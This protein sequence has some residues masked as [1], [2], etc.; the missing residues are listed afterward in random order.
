M[1]RRRSIV[2]GAGALALVGLSLSGCVRSTSA[3]RGIGVLTSAPVPSASP[4]AVDG[5]DA[6]DTAMISLD[7]G[8]DV[9]V[10]YSGLTATGRMDPGHH[11]AT[12]DFAGLQD[13]IGRASCRER[14]LR[15]V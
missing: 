4:S 3:V 7:R 8:Y 13:E 15:L 12:V 5:T 1:K 11:A 2:A 9:V 10:T 6:F 14:V